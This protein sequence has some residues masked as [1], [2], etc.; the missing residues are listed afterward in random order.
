ML[1]KAPCRVLVT[2][3]PGRRGSGGGRAGRRVRFNDWWN[4]FRMSRGMPEDCACPTYL[5][6]R[7]VR[8]DRRLRPRRLGDREAHDPA[9]AR[10]ER[11][12]REPGGARAARPRPGP[13]LG[14]R[15]RPVHGRH[16]A[17]GG[18]AQRGGHRTGRRGRL[19]HRRRQHEHHRGPDRQEALP[20]PEGGRARARPV[21]RGLVPAS[22]ACTPSARRRWRS[23][24]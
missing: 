9:G 21:S 24:C 23:T 1:E 11:A 10:G 15:R 5:T 17:R 3:P 20:G 13:D 6:G 8:T 18:R 22:R 19:L 12:R 4:S 16:R 2:A 14:G 7:H